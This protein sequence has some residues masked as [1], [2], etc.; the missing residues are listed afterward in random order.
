VVP[1]ARSFHCH[2]EGVNNRPL[3][4]TQLL[5]S[6]GTQ[7]LLRL[8]RKVTQLSLFISIR[9]ALGQIQNQWHRK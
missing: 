6:P 7:K 2:R 8:G 5:L 4:S 1:R 3:N 9:N